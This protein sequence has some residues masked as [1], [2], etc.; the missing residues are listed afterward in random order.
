MPKLKNDL[1]IIQAS[2]IGTRIGSGDVVSG[3]LYL[4]LVRNFKAYDRKRTAILKGSMLRIEKLTQ[5]NGRL[6]AE[7]KHYVDIFNSIVVECRGKDIVTRQRSQIVAL[8]NKNAQ[9]REQLRKA[10]EALAEKNSCEEAK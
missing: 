8:L 6:K 5:E 1:D 3:S 4:K 7:L 2:V 10:E 9:L